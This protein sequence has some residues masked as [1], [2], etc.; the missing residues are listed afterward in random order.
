MSAVLSDQLNIAEE[1]VGKQWIQCQDTSWS[2]Q[3]MYVLHT[4]VL[5]GG[6]GCSQI[7]QQQVISEHAGQIKG[8][9]T[10]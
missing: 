2:G 8:K 1:N 6:G 5:G 7:H 9:N 3:E 10:V 4:T